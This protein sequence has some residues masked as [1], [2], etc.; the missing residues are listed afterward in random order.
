MLTR[1]EKVGIAVGVAAVGAGLVAFWPKKA[2]AAQ[3]DTTT[4]PGPPEPGDVTVEA[5]YSAKP[6]VLLGPDGTFADLPVIR[7]AMGNT[8]GS[9]MLM[10]VDGA[11]SGQS[12]VYLQ[13][14]GVKAGNQTIAKSQLVDDPT[15]FLATFAGTM[16]ADPLGIL[17]R[18]QD[19]NLPDVVLM[20]L[21]PDQQ[22]SAND[23]RDI[24]DIRQAFGS[25][26]IVWI[27]AASTAPG[28]AKALTE[29]HPMEEWIRARTDDRSQVAFDAWRFLTAQ[30]VA[31]ITAAGG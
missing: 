4:P 23:A 11:G 29:A 10:F 7:P 14:L 8:P 17:P 24:A 15:H 25:Q 28:I 9:S 26:R 31:D 2:S 27:L 20:L 22:A 12:A 16:G 18:D 3:A 30:S 1:N 5:T 6:A 13:D 19:G 21:G